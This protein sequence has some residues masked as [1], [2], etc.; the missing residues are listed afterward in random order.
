MSDR[1]IPQDLTRYWLFKPHDDLRDAELCDV[2][3]RDRPNIPG[4]KGDNT[5]LTYFLFLKF[6]SHF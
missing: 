6:T 5:C 1:E 4:I 2:E 3:K